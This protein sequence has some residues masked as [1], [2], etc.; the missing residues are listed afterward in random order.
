MAGSSPDHS[1]ALSSRHGVTVQRIQNP[2]GDMGIRTGGVRCRRIDAQKAHSTLFP[3]LSPRFFL[4]STASDSH[5]NRKS[6]TRDCDRRAVVEVLGEE[7]SLSPMEKPRAPDSPTPPTREAVSP[8]I[9]WS[10]IAREGGN[11]ESQGT[12]EHMQATKAHASALTFSTAASSAARRSRGHLALS[13]SAQHCRGH[14]TPAFH[15]SIC[16]LS[17][18]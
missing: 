18:N 11:G 9:L 14:D 2:R 4:F 15:N 8:G 6:A 16:V 7:I 5:L 10:E 12:S 1:C 17:T 13:P 3:L